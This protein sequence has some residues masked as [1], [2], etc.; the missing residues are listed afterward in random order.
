M[1][2]WALNNIT[3]P[4]APDSSSTLGGSPGA[5]LSGI[6]RVNID[7]ANQAIYW[8]LC[9]S[10]GPSQLYT[11]GSWDQPVYMTPGSR[12]LIRAG[13]LGVRVWAATP[14]ANLPSS[15]SQAQVT[16]EAVQ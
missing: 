13:I 2:S 8:Q 15:V 6:T 11:S 3:A 5:W 7:C 9:L 4:D 1:S 14:A 10:S 12:T 16:V